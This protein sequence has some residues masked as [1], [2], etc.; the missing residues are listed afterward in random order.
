MPALQTK[1]EL[2]QSYQDSIE[3]MVAFLKQRTNG[4]RPEIGI[5]CGSGLGGLAKTVS[6]PQVISYDEIENFPKSTVEGHAGQLV[7][8]QIKGRNVVCMKGRFHYYE[9]YEAPQVS[10]PVKV[11]TALGIKALIVTN[12]AGGVNPSFKVGDLMIIKDQITMI[13]MTGVHPLVGPNDKRFGDRFTPVNGV[14]NAGF[15]RHFLDVASKSREGRSQRFQEGVYI[16]VTGPTYES[17]AEIGFFRQIGADSVGMSTVFE[18]L[19]AAHC[20]LPVLGLSLVTNRCMG[21]KDNFTP[22]THQEVLDAVVDSE[23]RIQRLVSDFVETVDLSG[24]KD[25]RGYTHFKNL[26]SRL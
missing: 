23:A 17:P 11:M 3:G 20:G 8:G 16:G 15:K 9:G 24:F 5:I 22:P 18:I 1:R 12:A 14:F 25:T 7:F 6:N 4:F 26:R 19:E 13:G 21:P 10:L 2:M